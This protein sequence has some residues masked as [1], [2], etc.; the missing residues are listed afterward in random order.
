MTEEYRFDRPVALTCPDC[1]GAMRAEHNG[2][3]LQYQCHIGHILT[4]ETLV[5]AQFKQLEIKIAAALVCLKERAELCRQ[6]SEAALLGREISVLKR[7][8]DEALERA[9]TIK[10]L[11][12][13]EWVQLTLYEK[14]NS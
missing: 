4:A 3:L 1:G 5:E 10:R 11:L 8:E 13:S 12:E 14:V 7:A 6:L 2:N 9:A